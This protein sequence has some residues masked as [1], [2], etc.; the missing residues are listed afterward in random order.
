M[1]SVLIGFPMIPSNLF[2]DIQFV[3]GGVARAI[4]AWAAGKAAAAA[5]SLLLTDIV[6]LAAGSPRNANIF[7]QQN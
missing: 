7:G 3:Q 4:G 1:H 5:A 2:Q 6:M